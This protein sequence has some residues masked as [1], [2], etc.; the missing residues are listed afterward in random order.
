MLDLFD[1]LATI[2]TMATVAAT[3]PAVAVG[4]S[5]AAAGE[6]AGK[7]S[8]PVMYDVIVVGGGLAGLTAAHRIIQKHDALQ[9]AGA[10]QLPLAAAAGGGSA[11]GGA[12]GGAG[13]TTTTN[14]SNSSCKSNTG[15]SSST[16]TTTSITPSVLVLEARD[17]LGG[18]IHTV[19]VAGKAIDLGAAWIREW[20]L[21]LLRP[22]CKH[23]AHDSRQRIWVLYPPSLALFVFQQTEPMATHCLQ[24][25]TEA[26]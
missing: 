16:T 3:T 5:D 14:S 9:R 12:G 4:S 2:A 17:Y 15:S 25:Q 18:R 22:E 21:P 8:L 1:K 6:P 24:L 20:T 23:A 11:G 19:E 7:G 10:T 26:A 13:A